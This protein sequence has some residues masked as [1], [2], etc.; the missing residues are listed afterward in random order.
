[1]K[2]KLVRCIRAMALG[3]GD[4]LE[5]VFYTVADFGDAVRLYSCV[6]CGTLFAASVDDE[7]HC[8]VSLKARI[9]KMKCPK[10][11]SPLAST[12]RPYPQDFR[13]SDGSLSHFEPD[14]RIPADSE[15]IEKEAW[16]LYG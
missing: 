8:G 4:V 12:L 14:R 11:T 16:N 15:G 9:D 6:T 2:K 1:M 3:T 7:H 10:C 13:A 5:E